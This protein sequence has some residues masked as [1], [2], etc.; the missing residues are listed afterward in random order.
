MLRAIICLQK[1]GL[2][3]ALGGA[4]ALLAQSSLWAY[5]FNFGDLGVCA[6]IAPPVITG[7]VGRGHDSRG[8]NELDTRRGT[9]PS[10]YGFW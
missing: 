9:P 3:A 10:R 4:L 1:R 5:D 6:I 7:V 8:A 2:I